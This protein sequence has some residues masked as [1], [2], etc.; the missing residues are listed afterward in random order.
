MGATITL[1]PGDRIGPSIVEAT[2]QVL[3]AAGAGLGV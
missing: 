2:I 3:E 1:I